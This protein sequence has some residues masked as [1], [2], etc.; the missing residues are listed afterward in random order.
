MTTR[1]ISRRLDHVAGA[2]PARSGPGPAISYDLR[3]LAGMAGS[4]RCRL[5]GLVERVERGGMAALSDAEVAEG[6]ALLGLAAGAV[7]GWWRR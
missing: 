6:A 2:L 1:T 4:Q 3:G 7:P 5:D